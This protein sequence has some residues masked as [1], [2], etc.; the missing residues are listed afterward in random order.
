MALKLSY[1]LES[2]DPALRESQIAAGDLEEDSKPRHECGVF[3]VFSSQ[4]NASRVAFF[5]LYALNHRESRPRAAAAR[6]L[7]W[8]SI[9]RRWG[10]ATRATARSGRPRCD[11]PMRATHYCAGHL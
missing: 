10:R 11:S 4:K 1:E 3:G 7:G 2:R 8:A 9:A 5:A 6:A